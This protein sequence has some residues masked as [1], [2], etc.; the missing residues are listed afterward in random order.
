MNSRASGVTV[1]RI[2]NVALPIEL[3]AKAG[4][5]NAHYIHIG[6]I[7]RHGAPPA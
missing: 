5:T 6:A 4:R 2:G 3:M 7:S 1:W